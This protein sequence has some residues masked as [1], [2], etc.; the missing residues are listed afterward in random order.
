[1]YSNE[2]Q[3]KSGICVFFGVWMFSR[4]C[5]NTNLESINISQSVLHVAVHHQLAETQHLSAKME[6][7]AESRLLSLL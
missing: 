3:Q 7:I 4:K 5:S 1:M 2:R 6:G